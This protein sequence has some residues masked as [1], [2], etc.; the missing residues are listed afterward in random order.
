MRT[1]LYVF[2]F[3]CLLSCQRSISESDLTKLN[4]YWEISEVEFADGTTKE[5]T[6]NTTIDFIEIAGFK[7]FR[8]KVQPTLEGTY[9][10]N[11][12]T[13]SFLILQKEDSFE[14]HYKNNLSEWNEM[15][16]AL[17]DNTFSVVNKEG[18]TY[19]YKRYEPINI[20]E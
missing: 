6:A 5:Y 8:K 14:F 16:T 2:A 12:D 17:T 15:L 4:G 18:I 9:Y 19:H 7:G 3:I 20:N 10:A 13:E 1:I 11:D